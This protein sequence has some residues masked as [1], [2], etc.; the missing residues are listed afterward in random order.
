MSTFLV[1]YGV[2]NLLMSLALALGAYAVHR[3]GRYPV[4]AHLLWVVVLVKLITPPLFTIPVI[5]IPGLGTELAAMPV[6]PGDA[7][8]VPEVVTPGVAPDDVAVVSWSDWATRVAIAVWLSGSVLITIRSLL[9]VR[10]FNH[11][12]HASASAPDPDLEEIATTT[13]SRFGLGRVPVIQMTSAQVSPMVWWIG[14]RVRIILP[15][16]LVERMSREEIRWVIAHELAHVRRR[17]HCVRWLEWL[18]CVACWW[19]PVAWW[20]RRNLRINEEICCDALVL[21]TLCP[22]P[23]TY[24]RSLMSVIDFLASPAIRPP[25][26]ASEITSGG[27]LERRFSMIMSRNGASRTPRWVCASVLALAIGAMPLGVAYGQDHD[28]VGKRLREAVESGELSGEQAKAMM[29]TLMEAERQT[30]RRVRERYARGEAELKEMVA[31]G[32][33]TEAQAEQR[34]NRMRHAIAER[35]E[36][37]DR[38]ER[39]LTLE[40]YRRAEAEIKELVAAGRVSEADGK[41]R[42]GEMRRA[43]APEAGEAERRGR[44]VARDDHGRVVAEL[45]AALVAGR[46]SE[47]DFKAKVEGLR[48]EAARAQQAEERELV[49]ERRRAEEG[50]RATVTRRSGPAFN[51]DRVG[52]A[53]RSAVERGELTPEEAEAVFGTLKQGAEARE[54]RRSYERRAAE[55]REVSERMA[56][57]K[58][59]A[60]EIEA[61]VER[62]ELS[63]EDA[64][65]KHREIRKR[66]AEDGRGR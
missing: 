15:A 64:D 38:R 34:L 31:A 10:R 51:W 1:E 18:A 24:A 58:N 32:Q 55:E 46:I 40:D 8:L 2:G 4:L 29:E 50:E 22:P 62:G 26:V 56:K 35:G 11:L 52:K 21:S 28:A 61:A 23:R 3:T 66:M 12:L 39:R 9:R 65:A 60:A 30:Q 37:A 63:R 17:D 41:A 43:I 25:A 20:A 53:I 48:R 7:V 42:L 54:V 45:K 5:P 57:W 19:N 47:A 59:V 6:D 16:Q 49:V 14:G 44:R 36:E 33:I 13:A 27:F